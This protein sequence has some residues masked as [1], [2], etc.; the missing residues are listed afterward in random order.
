MSVIVLRHG[1]TD[2]NGTGKE[3][4]ALRGWIDVPL[5]A[6]GIKLAQNAAQVLKDEPI[7]K[8][9]SSDLGRC[10]Q[11]AQELAGAIRKP[12]QMSPMFRPWDAGKLAGQPVKKILP[13]MHR[14][15]RNPSEKAP[16]G[17]SFQTFLDRYTRAIKPLVL[18]KQL[19]IVV[20]HARNCMVLEGLALGKGKAIDD[21]PLFEESRVH[22]A[23][24]IKVNPDWS[25]EIK[26]PPKQLLD[27]PKR[28]SKASVLYMHVVGSEY[29]C[30]DCHHYIEDTK[31]CTI[32]GKNDV[33]EPYGTC[34]LFSPGGAQ[35]SDE[36]HAPRGVLTKT[37]VGYTES[38]SGFTCK[39]CE[40]FLP[41]HNDCRRVDPDSAGD[42][43][44]AISAE[45]CCNNWES[46]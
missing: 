11:T 37:Q 39:N 41:D 34:G 9:L 21:R 33:I 32:L 16:G 46:I 27:R 7:F 42:D 13:E 4:E 26:N 2:L 28:L 43:P 1:P 35:T 18:S 44:H 10:V 23:G 19:Y 20:A 14:L 40:Y 12:F 24:I 6:Q 29:Q 8:I 31:R 45:A 22:P 15:M 5:N 3:D 30:H 17:E 36:V 38:K 25:Y